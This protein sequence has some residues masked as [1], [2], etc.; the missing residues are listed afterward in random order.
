M[1]FSQKAG[2]SRW[3]GDLP[4]VDVHCPQ[5]LDD[6]Q[7]LKDVGCDVR[8]FFFN[9]FHHEDVVA[10]LLWMFCRWSSSVS[11]CWRCRSKLCIQSWWCT[12]RISSGD[13][14]DVGCGSNIVVLISPTVGD[15]D[16]D[17][18]DDDDAIVGVDCCTWSWCNG[19]LQLLDHAWSWLISSITVSQ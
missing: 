7:R 11:R 9:R 6:V 17:D 15:D 2:N 3:F 16:D 19:G 1:E 10:F 12:S 5:L 8:L 4:D 14:V 18:D 13:A